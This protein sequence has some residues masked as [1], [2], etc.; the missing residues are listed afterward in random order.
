MKKPFILFSF[1]CLI[2]LLYAQEFI[3]VSGT[4][5]DESSGETMLSANV[6]EENTLA[7][8]VTNNYGYYSLQV[9]VGRVKIV[10]SFVGYNPTF[11]ELTLS[12]DTVINIS[13]SQNLEIKEV[14]V[15]SKGPQQTVETSQMSQIDLKVSDI[16]TAPVLLGETDILKTLQTMP[17]VQGGTEGSSGFF[18]RGGAPDQNLIL[19]D[20][21]PVYNVNHLFGFFSV[22]NADAIKNVSL[23][24]GGFP[25]RYGGRLSSVVDIRMK[26][27]NLKKWT[28]EGSIGILS[29]KI[30]VEGPIKKDVSSLLVSGRRTYYDLLTY[31]FQYA[32]NKKSGNT[33]GNLWFGAF[34]HDLNIKYNHILSENDR[35]YLSSY[36]GKDKFYARGKTEDNYTIDNVSY[37]DVYKTKN[38][39]GWGNITTALRWNH[40][41][42]P[43]LFS[44][45][46]ATFSDYTFKTN[47]YF[48]D[49]QWYGNKESFQE[50]D[51]QYYSRIRDIGLKYDFDFPINN[52]N[53]IRFGA[54]NT[55]HLFSPGVGDIYF[56]NS[57]VDDWFSDTTFGIK[58]IPGNVSYAYLEDDI[59]ITKKLK[60]NVGGH[61]S[62][63]NIEKTNY[64]SLEPRLSARYLLLD[65]LSIKSSYVQMTQ[66]INLITNSTIGL[67]T[68]LWVPSTKIL[69]PQKSWQA[70]TGL[71]Y[72][73]GNKY[74]ITLEGY[75]KEMESLVEFQEGYGFASLASNSLDDIITQG[76]GTSYGL[77]FFV[78]KTAGKF[79]G[80]LSYTLSKSDR[81]F[82]E[83]SLGRTF[84]FTY[85]RRHVI[86]I[87]TTWDISDRINLGAG[88][89]YYTGKAFTMSDERA[90]TVN[91]IEN[92]SDL[93]SDEYYYFNYPTDG[94][95]ITRNNYRMPIYHR[96]DLGIN[97]KKELRRSTRTLSIGAYNAYFRKNPFYVQPGYD[98][99]GI[100][101]PKR[102][103]KQVSIFPF[104]PFIKYSLKFN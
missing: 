61:L 24:K 97:F 32:Y 6:Y 17:G 16:K 1:L 102:V 46:T 18:V 60:I 99:N 34:F 28:G 35:I 91:Y 98:Y 3:T 30:T 79:R 10:Y 68:D 82:E 95:F 42:S 7:G 4:L 73:L 75:Y 88:W 86:A 41:H 83:I 29:S 92:S 38:G 31:P 80:W 45:L 84:P 54:S 48:F 52:N 50:F 78:N 94:F 67:P 85:D 72:N 58:N 51:A 25:A 63:F 66:Y 33:D 47:I 13:L 44:N 23:I 39:I 76:V 70:A 53:Y 56:N 104:V 26:E 65:N 15:T 36:I 27:G 20:G 64:F 9:P 100:D 2:N 19:L 57:D 71:A 59:E 90:I 40:L 69:L 87:I 96:L 77:E 8:T 5:S 37:T 22:F 74:E 103:I 12:K 43:K 49:Q 81:T 62:F 93:T 101:E 55:L 14:V 21:V 89:T 11:L